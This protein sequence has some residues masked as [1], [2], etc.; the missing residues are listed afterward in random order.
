MR[1]LPQKHVITGGP[2]VGKTTTLEIL[3]QRG[4]ETVRE[5]ARDIISLQQEAGEDGILPWTDNFGFQYLV[6]DTLLRRERQATGEHVFCDRGAFDAIAYCKIFGN[7][8]PPPLMNVAKTRRYEKV[9]LLDQL[10]NYVT[11]KERRESPELANAI[12][13]AIGEAYMELGCDVIRVPV[14]PPQER[15]DYIIERIGG[16]ETLRTSYIVQRQ[17]DTAA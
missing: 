5:T 17:Q 12:H 8:L 13:Q 6:L 4:Y 1:Y 16:R 10:P 7:D 3:A 15:A 9:F 14:L 11:D 2:G